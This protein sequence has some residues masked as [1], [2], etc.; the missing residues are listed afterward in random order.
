MVHCV[1]FFIV[2][3]NQEEIFSNLIQ[4]LTSEARFLNPI[5]CGVQGRSTGG[6]CWGNEPNKNG[7]LGER[8]TPNIKKSDFSLQ[9]K[10]DHM[11][12]TKIHTKKKR[13]N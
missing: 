9:N 1:L 5:T 13:M 8:G 7:G 11:S 12:K 3:K 10:I 2:K 4:A 6:G